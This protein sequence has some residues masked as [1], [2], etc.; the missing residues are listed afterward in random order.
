MRLLLKHTFPS[1][2]WNL[3]CHP[4]RDILFI[5]TRQEAGM[6]VVYSALDMKDNNF[7]WKEI[8]IT[9]NWWSGMVAANDNLLYLHEYPDG[10][11]PD[12]SR[13]LAYDT[14]NQKI[15]WQKPDV[16][17]D[18]C[19]VQALVVF[20]KEGRNYLDK[21]SGEKIKIQEE[22]TT[23]PGPVV[24][25]QS[26]TEGGKYHATISAFLASRKGQEVKGHLEYLEYKSHVFI[27]YYISVNERLANFL[28]VMNE[29]GE[30]VL[31]ETLASDFIALGWNT[32]FVCR[33]K[34]IFIQNKSILHMYEL[35]DKR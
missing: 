11:N 4:Q 25:P 10:R 12:P 31:F 23:I 16:R 35:E 21:Y 32:F 20:T 18:A 7:L 24:Y 26:Y 3:L 5:E 9:A 34:L 1:K 17:L 27:S 28:L 14:D 22:L 15:A 13:L 8:A 33:E 29:N 19:G 6:N 2:V 30:E